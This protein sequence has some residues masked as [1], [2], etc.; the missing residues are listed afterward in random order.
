MHT[1]NRFGLSL[2]ISR[3]T[4]TSKQNS[5]PR[6]CHSLPR[7]KTN[8]PACWTKMNMSLWKQILVPWWF[9]KYT[10]FCIHLFNGFHCLVGCKK[11]NETSSTSNNFIG[12]HMKCT[13]KQRW[14]Q[15]Y[16]YCNPAVSHKM[17]SR[18]LVAHYDCNCTPMFCGTPVIL[19]Q[20][21][22][23]TFCITQVLVATGETNLDLQKTAIISAAS[24]LYTAFTTIGY[25]I[26]MFLP[27]RPIHVLS[28]LW[29]AVNLLNNDC[30]IPPPKCTMSDLREYAIAAYFHIFLPHISQL[31]G[32]HILKKM[33][34]FFWHA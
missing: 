33:S 5:R 30:A 9:T 4:T 8:I 23:N 13:N 17:L 7:P 27:I 20:Q 18:P 1:E 34:A 19:K 2:E 16:I 31:H 22:A 15:F 12:K 24:T 26:G 29:Y 32:P 11:W 21:S 10:L 25:W 6:T 28:R 14:Y 3:P